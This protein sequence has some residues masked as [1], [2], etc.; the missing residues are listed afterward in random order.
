MRWSVNGLL[1]SQLAP[2]IEHLQLTFP[3]FVAV[4]DLPLEDITSKVSCLT[5]EVFFTQVV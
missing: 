4:D 1:C 3:E 2:A 5:D